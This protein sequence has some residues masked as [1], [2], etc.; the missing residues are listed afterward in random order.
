M[1]AHL[2]VQSF[3]SRIASLP[4]LQVINACAV[5]TGGGAAVTRYSTGRNRHQRKVKNNVG[6]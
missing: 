1:Y 4:V 2:K 6:P 3:T 5:S